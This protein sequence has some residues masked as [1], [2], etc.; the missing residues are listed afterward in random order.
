M[1]KERLD[2]IIKKGKGEEKCEKVKQ[3]LNEQVIT[4]HYETT[5]YHFDHLHH[6]G[7]EDEE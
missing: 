4:E 3:F 1:A 5:A 7:F 2:K 6:E